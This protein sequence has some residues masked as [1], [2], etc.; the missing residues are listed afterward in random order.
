MHYIELTQGSRGNL[1]WCTTCGA[2]GGRS[3][4]WTDIGQYYELQYECDLLTNCF[5]MDNHACVSGNTPCLGETYRLGSVLDDNRHE[6]LHTKPH[7][8]HTI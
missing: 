8:L 5:E 3:S 7:M 4:G 1:Y 2:M 6:Q